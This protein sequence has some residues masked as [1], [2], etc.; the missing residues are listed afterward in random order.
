MNRTLLAVSLALTFGAIPL[1]AQTPWI[2]VEVDENEADASH[3][4]GNLALSVVE[5]ALGAGPGDRRR[6]AVRGRGPG[7]EPEGR[8]LRA[9]EPPGRHR[10]RRRRRHQG[11]HLDRRE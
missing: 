2:H 7:A 4:K 3:I 8:H 11:P 9:Q 5:M 10:P 1:Q 6:R